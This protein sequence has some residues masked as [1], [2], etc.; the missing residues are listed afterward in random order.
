MVDSRNLYKNKN[1]VKVKQKNRR[2]LRRNKTAKFKTNLSF[3][4]INAAGIFSKLP[5][6]NNVLESL[7]PTVFFIEET[8]LRKQG[9]IKTEET[10]HYQI[11]ELNRKDKQGGGLAIGALDGVNPVWIREGSDDVEILVIEISVKDLKIRCICGYGPQEGDTSDRKD[12]FWAK[13]EFEVIDAN[14]NEACILIQMDGNLW[15]GPELIRNDPNCCNSNGKLFKKFLENNPQLTV[16]NN[17]DLCEG[18]ITRSRKTVKKIE[19]SILD[20]FIVCEKLKAYLKKMIIDEE[21]QYTLSR[22]SKSGIKVDTDHN[23]LIMYLDIQFCTKKPGRVEYFNFKNQ[24]CQQFFFQETSTTTEFEN[25]FEGDEGI[26]VQGTNWFRKLNRSFHKSF[27]K[28]R[29]N[30]KSKETNLTQ[31]FDKRRE[32]V[33]K[34]K[35]CEDNLKAETEKE[36][37]EIDEEIVAEENKDKVIENFKEFANADGLLNINGMWKIK[38]KIFPKNKESLPL[39]KKGF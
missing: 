8:K 30:G 25:C 17:L 12:R 26:N 21:K 19:K 20:F 23:P 16:V 28:V 1:K 27:K 2:G 34:M 18:S 31:L 36:L 24:D 39:A 6:F 35:K 14:L 10:K 3:Y 33:Q 9:S 37:S 11:F 15:G 7:K 38:R 22:Y 32:L 5:S 29:F 13:L 4:G